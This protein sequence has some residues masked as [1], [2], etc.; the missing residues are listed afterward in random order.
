M[1]LTQSDINVCEAD[2]LTREKPDN[3]LNAEKNWEHKIK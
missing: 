2:S 3:C 1:E